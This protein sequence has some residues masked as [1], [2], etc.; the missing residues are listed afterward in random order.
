MEK[1]FNNIDT[2]P[3]CPLIPPTVGECQ[4]P[5]EKPPTHQWLHQ[6]NILF[7]QSSVTYKWVQ[8][9]RGLYYTKLKRLVI[10]KYSSLLDPF[11][12]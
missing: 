7:E 4:T 10:D 5:T 12:S 8:Y 2:R 3:G 1:Q 11:I 6:V 9:A